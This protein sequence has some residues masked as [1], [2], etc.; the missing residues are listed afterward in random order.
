[1]ARKDHVV[2]LV[3][4]DVPVST[5]GD[6]DAPAAVRVGALAEKWNQLSIGPARLGE[7]AEEATVGI[8]KVALV[9]S[10]AHGLGLHL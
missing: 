5:R 8:A 9:L 2:T 4:M 1:V 6:L 7:D 10:T 3:D